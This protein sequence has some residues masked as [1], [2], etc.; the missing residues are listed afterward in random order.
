MSDDNTINCEEAL[1]RLFR[2]LDHDLDRHRHAEM[3][4]HLARCKSCYSRVEFEK[5]LHGHL[6]EVGQQ[7]PSD[8][9][10]QR[11]KKLI[12]EQ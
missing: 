2:F 12:G 8:A 10:R 1:K 5:R 9:L 6:R 7:L 4:T 11:I 3:E